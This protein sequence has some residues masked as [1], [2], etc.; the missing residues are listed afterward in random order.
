[1]LESVK[2]RY[3][4]NRTHSCW[5][6]R[7]KARHSYMSGGALSENVGFPSAGGRQTV[8][9]SARGYHPRTRASTSNT[10]FLFGHFEYSGNT[11]KIHGRKI[12]EVNLTKKGIDNKKLGNL[13]RSGRNQ[14]VAFMCINHG[15]L[16]CPDHEYGTALKQQNGKSYI[17][18]L[19]WVRVRKAP[20]S[21]SEETRWSLL[22]HPQRRLGRRPRMTWRELESDVKGGIHISMFFYRRARDRRSSIKLGATLQQIIVSLKNR[23]GFDVA[24]LV[25]CNAMHSW[26]WTIC[27]GVRVYSDVGWRLLLLFS[28]QNL[29]Q[30]LWPTISTFIVCRRSKRTSGTNDIRT[31]WGR[32]MMMMICQW[33]HGLI[34]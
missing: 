8:I 28:V 33:V 23:R 29:A 27:L 30:I 11:W 32:Q 31:L 15:V 25:S 21:M 18:Q 5:G 10:K 22:E 34:D 4:A 24:Y 7:R 12:K 26:Q 13:D 6:L 20:C 14:V 2:P 19:E 3:S 16:L 9:S 1:M 17:V